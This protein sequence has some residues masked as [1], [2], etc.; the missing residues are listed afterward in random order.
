MKL[1]KQRG[2]WTP[3]GRR[4]ARMLDAVDA[5]YLKAR[6]GDGSNSKKAGPFLSTALAPQPPLES[7]GFY[8][9]GLIDGRYRIVGSATARGR[10]T[11]RGDAGS[12]TFN[13]PTFAFLGGG[14]GGVPR[15][16][17]TSNVADFDGQVLVGGRVD[18]YRSRTG[19][20]LTPFFSR[21]YHVTSPFPWELH[22]G[23][24]LNLGGEPA[25]QVGLSFMR[26]LGG[27]HVPSFLTHAQGTS[28]T[29]SLPYDVG[30]LNVRP[31]IS[32][33]APGTLYALVPTFWPTYSPT[34]INT[35][36]TPGMRFHRSD[37][38]GRTWAATTDLDLVFS[39]ELAQLRTNLTWSTSTAA[40]W[41]N[42]VAFSSFRTYSPAPDV[43]VFVAVVPYA[44]VISGTTVVKGRVKVGR[45]D[46]TS[47][48]CTP[49]ATIFD[50]DFDDALF[51]A[52][53]GGIEC[54]YN[55]QAGVMLFV[56]PATIDR[57][58]QPRQVLWTNGFT[59]VALGLMPFPNYATGGV[60]A[61][62][63]GLLICPM[64]DG[65][66]SL[67]QS[68]DGVVW[69]KRATIFEGGPVPNPSRLVLDNFTFVTFLR[70]GG[71]PA[72]LTPQA[73][74]MS[75]YRKGVP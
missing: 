64:Y 63:P 58:A 47:G 52:N 6:N 16:T 66:Y 49:Y 13:F 68:N 19:K 34:S 61:I 65:Q 2:G 41:N 12:Q 50:G 44:A 43:Q 71:R 25:L 74:W 30:Q 69:R 21:T 53:A 38:G 62:K 5:P 7:D 45:R 72:L 28:T 20:Q 14:Y 32:F 54:P 17:P 27:Q 22:G 23:R 18:I 40:L 75:D 42:A 37:D 15:I 35:A 36:A 51:F 55:G 57:P 29:V 4:K 46:P 33:V 39:A 1:V 70:D 60:T 31:G 8:S 9:L 59:T 11:D 24:T 48:V 26:V 67:Y 3:Q 73:P 56:R 10:F